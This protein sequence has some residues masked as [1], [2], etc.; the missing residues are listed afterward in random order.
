MEL[1]K[2]RTY[3]EQISILKF[4]NLTIDDE[5][6]A[7]SVLKNIGY[8]KLSGYYKF[9]YK[10]LENTTK[11]E[12]IDGAKFEE[13]HNLYLFDKELRNLLFD[14]I[15][16]V[17]VSFKSYISYTIAHKYGVEVW[18]DNRILPD[19]VRLFIRNELDRSKKNPI[20]RH[21][22]DNYDGKYPVWVVM[23][24]LSFGTVSKIYAALS[25]EDKKY[26][27]AFY[28]NHKRQYIEKW[29]E[30]IT[31]LRNKCAHNER[32]LGEVIN[33]KMDQSMKKG[34]RAGTLFIVILS[35]KKLV[36]DDIEWSFFIDRLIRIF[37][38]Y[39]FEYLD[40]LGFCENWHE[41]LK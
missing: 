24:I 5:D 11:K 34:Y 40:I 28:Y 41:I 18:K 38:N 13:I 21:H 32:I 27:A 10:D 6:Y 31:N 19:N 20:I 33:I 23:E 9:F 29:M 36:N 35:L 26:I 16:S 15:S 1:K 14:I 4:K 37:D 22:V 12:F 25:D 2:A 39:K 8:Y 3:E 17:E 7:K 30:S